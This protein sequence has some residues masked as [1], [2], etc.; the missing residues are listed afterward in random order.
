M[1][2]ADSVPGPLDQPRDRPVDAR[3]ETSYHHSMPRRRRHPSLIPLW[4]Q[5]RDAL[6]LAFRLR[7]PAP[8]APVTPMTPASTPQSRA[9]DTLAFYDQH[10]RGHF[11]AEEDELFPFLRR[12]QSD[13]AAHAALFEELA[14]QHRRLEALRDAIAAAD[15][16]A[17]LGAA[18]ETFAELLET[19]VRREERELFE[20][21]PDAVPPEETETLA[22]AIRSLA[23]PPEA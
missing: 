21:F 4:Q 18:L 10:L 3:S 14:A 1:I 7:H 15:G 9:V 11:R 20:N 12:R 2:L 23:R 22:A 5:H 19:H 13:D 16:E 17:A 8:P 6:M